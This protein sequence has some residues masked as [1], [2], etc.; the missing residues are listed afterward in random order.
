VLP[1]IDNLNGK[2][3]L[4]NNNNNNKNQCISKTFILVLG[5]NFF[6]LKIH[7]A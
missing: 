7:N 4:N 6:L 1:D 2:N 5:W 3:W